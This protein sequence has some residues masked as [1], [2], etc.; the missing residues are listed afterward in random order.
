M[1]P[2]QNDVYLIIDEYWKKFGY[3]PT[4]EDVMYQLNIKSKASTHRMMMRLVELGACKHLPNKSRT[5]RPAG[6]RFKL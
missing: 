2:R 3:G 5:I 1:T 6:M 4:V